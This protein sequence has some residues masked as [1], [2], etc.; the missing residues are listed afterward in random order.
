[1]DETIPVTEINAN[2]ANEDP[3][4]KTWMEHVIGYLRGHTN[5]TDELIRPHLRHT[6]LGCWQYII[7]AY[8][9][10]VVCGAAFNSM[11][12]YFIVKYR[13]YRDATYVYLINLSICDLVKCVV[14]LPFSVMTL[15][16]QNFLF[17]N[18]LCF[19]MP[20]LQVSEKSKGCKYRILPDSRRLFPSRETLH[21]EQTRV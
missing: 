12:I 16:L 18:F 11:E 3:Q 15:L 5:N 4:L 21:R 2:F 19:F 7:F 6:F 20:M 10:L 17:G 9:L 8:L 14:V 13:L 1:M